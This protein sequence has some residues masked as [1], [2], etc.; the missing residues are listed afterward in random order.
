MTRLVNILALAL[1]LLLGGCGG[2]EPRTAPTTEPYGD[3]LVIAALTDAMIIGTERATARLQQVDGYWSDPDLRIPLPADVKSLDGIMRD[4]GHGQFI[5]DL[6]LALN[7]AAEGAADEIMEFLMLEIARLKWQNPGR[8]LNGKDNAASVYLR[9]VTGGRLETEIRPVIEHL[10]DNSPGYT[11]WNR[12]VNRSIREQ[13]V[14]NPLET[15]LVVHTTTWALAGF[16][17]ALGQE[18]QAIRMQPDQQTTD[19]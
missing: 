8:I 10:L 7:H 5:D 14:L 18:E 1:V 2:G 13:S 17:R 3:T 12:N 9:Q 19:L 15:D 4:A 11:T 6:H 16:F